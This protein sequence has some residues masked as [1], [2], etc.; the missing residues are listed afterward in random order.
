MKTIIRKLD[1]TQQETAFKSKARAPLVVQW[2]RIHLAI[3]GTRFDPC[4]MKISH[5]VDN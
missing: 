2:L 5:A 4:S 1:Y 3:Q